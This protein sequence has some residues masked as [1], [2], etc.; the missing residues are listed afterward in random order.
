MG[1]AFF[2]QLPL[3]FLS[4]YALFLRCVRTRFR[5]TGELRYRFVNDVPNQYCHNAAGFNR[6]IYAARGRADPQPIIADG[7]WLWA[8]AGLIFP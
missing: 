3:T 4:P 2:W 7:G 8:G 6:R 5:N 1:P